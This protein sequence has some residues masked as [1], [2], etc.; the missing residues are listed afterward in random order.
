MS[1][2]SVS[3]FLNSYAQNMGPRPS[4]A[5]CLLYSRFWM[6]WLMKASVDPL[7]L[8]SQSAVSAGE[9]SKTCSP[10]TTHARARREATDR[11]VATPRQGS[12]QKYLGIPTIR[13]LGGQADLL[14]A[15]V[16]LHGDTK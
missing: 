12:R 14:L 5:R 6:S 1:N 11:M 2:A 10:A 8:A 7:E 13:I 4:D 9:S 15:M 16:L 3:T